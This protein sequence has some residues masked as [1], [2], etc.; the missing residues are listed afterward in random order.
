MHLNYVDVKLRLAEHVAH[1]RGGMKNFH[2]RSHGGLIY[3]RIILKE[4]T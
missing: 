4:Y 3:L 2:V 1:L